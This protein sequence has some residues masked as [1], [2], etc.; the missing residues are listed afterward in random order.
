MEDV[1]AKIQ[2]IG[3]RRLNVEE[4]GSLR[5]LARF[6][7]EIAYDYGYG[8]DAVRIYFEGGRVVCVTPEGRL[9]S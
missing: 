7:E 6:T 3:S 2:R 1:I 5:T 9:Y 8:I 4:I